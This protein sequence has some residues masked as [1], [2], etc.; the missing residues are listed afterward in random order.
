VPAGDAGLE[1]AEGVDFH[2][3]PSQV[4]Q[5]FLLS[6]RAG[7]SGW[8]QKGRHR[9]GFG[10]FIKKRDTDPLY[11]RSVHLGHSPT[12]TLNSAPLE[13]REISETSNHRQHH[14]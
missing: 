9:E 3:P 13:S 4:E 12:G 5:D 7:K 11:S 6:A 14:C 1:S 8:K 2:C 10:R